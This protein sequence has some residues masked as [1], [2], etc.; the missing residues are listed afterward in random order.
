MREIE[1]LESL[2]RD[3]SKSIDMETLR[4]VFEN[5]SLSESRYKIRFF[6]FISP[7]PPID[8]IN[9]W[10][11]PNYEAN[12][13]S[14]D[15]FYIV[16]LSRTIKRVDIE[17]GERTVTGDF[18]LF[19]S[20]ES[21]IWT[22]FTSDS[23]DFFKIAVIKFIET[24]KPQITRIF[25]SSEELRNLFENIEEKLEADI[26]VKKAIMY[27]FGKSG[28]IEYEDR[29]YQDIFNIAENEEKY[30][31]KLEFKLIKDKSMIYH[32]FISRDGISYYNSGHVGLFFNEFLPIISDRSKLKSNLFKDKSREYGSREIHPIEI[33]FSKDVFINTYDNIRFIKAISKLNQS[34]LAVYHKNPYVHLSLIDYIDGSNFD[35]Y[36]TESDKVN[37]VPNFNCSTHSLMRICEDIFKN[38]FEGQI[39]E[40]SLPNYS[41]SDFIGDEING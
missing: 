27:S 26:T 33:Q 5:L 40:P 20:E 11:E 34:A 17:N 14:Y 29:P 19:Q 30:I 36:A 32:G 16:N 6:T 39:K 35:I 4:K 31:D 15:D 37:I 23:P 13:T 24:Y 18:G 22:V 1:L 8:L 38:F 3:E 7:R 9:E 28:R 10:I 12:V 41:L 2:Y 21:N 25:L